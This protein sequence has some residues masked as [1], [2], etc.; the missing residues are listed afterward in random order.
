MKLVK[1][2]VEGD[3]LLTQ[4][5]VSN[6]SKGVNASGAGYL[7][8]EL[9]D[10]SGAIS[11]KKWEVT[12][13]DDKIFTV[14]NIVEVK[15]EIIM[16]RTS[17]QGKIISA[18]LMDDENVDVAKFVKQPPIPKEE[19]IKRFNEHVESIQNPEC[20]KVVTYFVKKFE[21]KLYDHPAASS[22]HHEYSSGLLMHTVSMANIA[23]S[24]EKMYP[25]VSHD[26]LI[27]GII[28][29]DFGKMKELEGK[30][31]YKYSLE[32]KLLGHISIMVGEIRKACAELKISEEIS[33][34]LEHMVLA[35]H[36]QLEYGS[37]VLPLTREALLISL[38]DNLDSKMTIADKALEVTEN[39][40]F[41]QKIFALDSRAMYKHTFK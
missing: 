21:D 29:H 22:I 28:L 41:S 24:V 27:S 34:L 10:S 9:R 26:L 30:V 40:D 8:V 1:E 38:I 36:G 37:P 14:G 31:A 11:A 39:N 19:L 5:L 6:V 3:S 18:T 13:E 17:L 32:G 33:L 25:D 20:K 16:Y 15:L 4:L 2:F 23:V 35:H 7:N 12:M